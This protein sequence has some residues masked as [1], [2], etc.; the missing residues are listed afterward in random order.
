MILCVICKVLGHWTSESISVSLH[1]YITV[2]NY[3]YYVF[4]VVHFCIGGDEIERLT[5]V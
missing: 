4:Y 5:P 1:A 3:N 2:H